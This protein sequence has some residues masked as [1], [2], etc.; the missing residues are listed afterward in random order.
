[1]I[2]PINHREDIR[3]STLAVIKAS[4]GD[5]ALTPASFAQKV[6]ETIG[7]ASAALGF[8]QQ[9]L[10]H[11]KTIAAAVLQELYYPV[12]VPKRIEGHFDKPL[13]HVTDEEMSANIEALSKLAEADDQHA[14]AVD[15]FI[16]SKVQK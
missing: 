6:I 4:G 10:R 3:Q 2:T 1:M 8:Q 12:P 9:A 14:D 5:V 11:A 16:A 15:T 13:D 7:I